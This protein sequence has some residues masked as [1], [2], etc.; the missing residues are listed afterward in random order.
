LTVKALPFSIPLRPVILG[1]VLL[2]FYISTGTALDLSVAQEVPAHKVACKFG[3]F[4]GR[5]SVLVL[6]RRICTSLEQDFAAACISCF[7]CNQQE[8]IPIA[9][10]YRVKKKGKK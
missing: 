3:D 5:Q 4:V 7:C 8:G 6:Q 2:F 9:V 1:K 10:T